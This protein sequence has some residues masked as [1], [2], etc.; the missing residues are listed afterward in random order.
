MVGVDFG[1]QFRFAD[2]L[3]G[4]DM[5]ADERRPFRKR[6]PLIEKGPGCLFQQT[7]H[8]GK[9]FFPH[10]VTMEEVLERGNFSA[11]P[12]AA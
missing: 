9:D 1:Q 12:Q 7:G 5:V 4:Q 11:V 6:G 2:L 3:E 10:R 8:A